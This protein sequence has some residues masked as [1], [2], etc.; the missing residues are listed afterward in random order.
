MT[1]FPDAA[2]ISGRL[3]AARDAIERALSHSGRPGPVGIL[4]VT[5]TLPVEVLREALGA[6][7]RCFGENRVSEGGR[8]IAALGRT[9]AEFHLIGPLH[10]S[11]ARQAVRDFS[12]IDSIDR[13]EVLQAVLE[14]MG[15]ARTPGLLLEINTTPGEAKHGFPPDPS[16]IERI[17][18]SL[19]ETAPVP[20]GFLTVGPFS[21]GEPASRASFAAL[22]ALRDEVER[23]TGRRLPD[24]SMGMSDDF[25]VAVEEGATTVRLGRFLF[26]PRRM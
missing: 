8:K 4:A 6:G 19:A 24:L 13:P 2:G 20:R 17:L 10:R 9:A 21:G 25:E 12:S 16:V 14:R 3:A 23:R 5:K 26:G 22:R 18:G 7:I 1:V 11:E 15:D